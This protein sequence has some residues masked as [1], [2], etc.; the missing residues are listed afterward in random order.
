[1]MQVVSGPAMA[2]A[3]GLSRLADALSTP[4]FTQLPAQLGQFTEVM[5]EMSKRLGP[6]T[7]FA[8]SAGGLFGGLRLPGMA[9][10][11]RPAPSTPGGHDVVIHERTIAARTGAR[12]AS[13]RPSRRRRRRRPRRR[14]RRREEG[15]AAEED[16]A[17]RSPPRRRPRAEALISGGRT[18]STRRGPEVP[19][20]ERRSRPVGLARVAGGRKANAM[21]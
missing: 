10:S 16:G 2:V 14:R 19:C 15:T 11:P 17:P 8:E 12:S 9:S 18:A 7:Q 6:L 21:P 1:M 5:T 13:S 4:G 3:P 20:R